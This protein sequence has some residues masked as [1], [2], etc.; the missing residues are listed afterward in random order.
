MDD[1][2]QQPELELAEMAY[3]GPTSLTYLPVL[4]WLADNFYL[5]GGC[6]V[7]CRLLYELYIETCNPDFKIQVHPS[8]FGKLIQLVFPGLVTRKRT[9]AGSIR[10]HYDGIAIKK[11]SSFYARFC[12]LLYEQNYL[13]NCSPGE[14]SI[15]DVQ[16]STSRSSWSSENAADYKKNRQKKGTVSFRYIRHNKMSICV[17]NY[18][19]YLICTDEIQ[20][21]HLLQ[22]NLGLCNLTTCLL[23]PL[24]FH[25]L[26]KYFCCL[27]ISLNNFVCTETRNC[28]QDNC[29]LF[30][31]IVQNK[32][33]CIKSKNLQYYPSVIY[34]KTEQETFHYLSPDFNQFFFGEQAQSETYPYELIALLANDY[35]SYCQ[36]ILQMVRETKLDKVED[37]IMSFWTSLQPERIE[38][39]CLPDVCQ[40]LKS[41]DRYLFKELENILLPDFLEEVPAQ[42]I[43][44]IRSFSENVKCWMLNPLGGFPLL[45]QTSKSNEAKEFVKRLRRQTDLCN[46]VKT[47]RALLNNNSTVTVLRSGL[48]AIFNEKSLDVIK[49]LFQEFRNPKKRQKNIQLKCLKNFISLLT[50]STDIRDLLSSLSSDLQTFVIKPSKSKEA[51]K[52]QAADFM[53]KWNLLLSNVGKILTINRTDSFGSWLLLNMLLVDF[54][55]HIF[56]SYIEEEKEEG[57]ALVTNQN[58]VPVLCVYEPSH[59]T[60]C[61]AEEEPQANATQ[62]SLVMQNQN[63]FGLTNA[64][65]SS[66]LFGEH[67][68]C[69]QAHPGNLGRENYYIMY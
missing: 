26:A 67:S 44:S 14:V 37:C 47:V 65:Q 16:P 10:Y 40:L 52:E 69:Q 53:L 62:T 58:E 22:N 27:N 3:F 39:M 56:Q 15:S 42:H 20:L 63:N 19:C 24:L 60:A 31:F 23:P 13:R 11:E 30:F 1:T 43:D 5:C 36:V 48:H 38:L 45:L 29:N 46:M 51:F 35:Y 49:D 2:E 68:H 6:T 25:P 66:E 34:L 41:Y 55:A 8:T 32:F 4:Q 17:F 61:F 50:S 59:L 57:N 12:C 54:A 33:W 9:T 28:G 64:F 18:N 7:P 21:A